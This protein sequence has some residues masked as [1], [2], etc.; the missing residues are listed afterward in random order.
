MWDVKEVEEEIDFDY[1]YYNANHHKGLANELNRIVG[2]QFTPAKS[3]LIFLIILIIAEFLNELIKRKF[4]SSFKNTFE[5]INNLIELMLGLR[6][7]IYTFLT[8]PQNTS[9]IFDTQSG[10][11]VFKRNSKKFER[12]EHKS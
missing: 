11:F 5:K 7:R 8:N 12:I 3:F 6:L 4:K 1:C 10:F 2:L 9:S